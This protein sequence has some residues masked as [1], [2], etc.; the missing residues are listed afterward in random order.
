MPLRSA[1]LD[2]NEMADLYI[3]ADAILSRCRPRRKCMHTVHMLADAKHVQVH[4]CRCIISQGWHA[5]RK[6][7]NMHR[8]GVWRKG[9]TDIEGLSEHWTH[10]DERGASSHRKDGAA[11]KGF[12]AP[13]A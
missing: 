5:T 11:D 7:G 12:A 10:K 3:T 9:R 2:D 6:S 4:A 8:G 1:V 13:C